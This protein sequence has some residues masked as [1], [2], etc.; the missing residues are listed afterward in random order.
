M[1]LAITVLSSI[2]AICSVTVAKPVNPSA[3]TS[4]ESST[5]TA[6]PSAQTTGWIN[7]DQLSDEG[8]NLIKEYARV[9]KQHN[10][11]KAMCGSTESIIVSQEKLVKGL[12][13]ELGD[14][15]DKT[16]KSKDGSEY[17]EEVKKANARFAEQH[18]LL[19]QFEKK[20]MDSYWDNSGIRS[21]LTKIKNELVKF[22]FGEHISAELVEDY[23]QLLESDFMFMKLVKEFEALVLDRQLEPEQPSTS[24]IQSPQHRGNLPSSSSQTPTVQSTK[25]SSGKRKASKHPSGGQKSRKYS[26]E[27]KTPKSSYPKG[28]P[29]RKD[30]FELLSNPSDSED[31]D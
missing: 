11:A 10:E 2:L 20:C 21:Q 5:S 8:M 16:H 25:A 19:L 28:T 9:N 18:Y 22:L 4:V 15:M 31:S 7:F 3:T 30:G 12:A 26:R 17:E 14:L 13:S 27:Q 29:K 23:M 1:K 24:G 6:V